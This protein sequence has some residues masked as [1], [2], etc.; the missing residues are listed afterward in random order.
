VKD[1]AD[2]MFRNP[3]ALSRV[4]NVVMFFHIVVTQGYFF[5]KYL[6]MRLLLQ[7]DLQGLDRIPETHEVVNQLFFLRILMTL[8]GYQQREGVQNADA[9][10]LQNWINYFLIDYL[11]LSG[12]RIPRM[13]FLLN[14][15]N[16]E[17]TKMLTSYLNTIR[18]NFSKVYNRLVNL[19]IDRQTRYANIVQQLRQLHGNTLTQDNFRQLLR[20]RVRLE[21]IDLPPCPCLWR[22]KR[23]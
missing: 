22:R 12:Y 8:A 20:E 1:N 7:Q 18:M 16:Y 23:R 3:E 13:S 15:L 9:R 11:H 10:R 21:L 2:S 6:F 5:A 4:R 17:A 19:S 14:V